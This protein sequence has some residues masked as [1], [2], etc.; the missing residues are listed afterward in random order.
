VIDPDL[1]RGDCG[2]CP[3][4]TPLDLAYQQTEIEYETWL[5]GAET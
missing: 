5:E 4:L 3:A 2:C 1:A